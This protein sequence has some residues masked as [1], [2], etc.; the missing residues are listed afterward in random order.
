M[1]THKYN[2]RPGFLESGKGSNGRAAAATASSS[3]GS[4]AAAADI[5]ENDPAVS[6]LS[7]QVRGKPYCLTEEVLGSAPRLNEVIAQFDREVAST[8][9]SPP[10]LVTDGQLHVRQALFPQAQRAGISLPS[11][12]YQVCVNLSSCTT[13]YVIIDIAFYVII[14]TF[15]CTSRANCARHMHHLLSVPILTIENYFHSQVT[16]FFMRTKK[17]LNSVSQKSRIDEIFIIIAKRLTKHKVKWQ[18]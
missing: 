2:V 12:F 13:F 14:D 6:K 17:V 8:L 1:G 9:P 5:N 7:D 18:H 16:A 10:R 11:Y 15:P 4:T 3:N